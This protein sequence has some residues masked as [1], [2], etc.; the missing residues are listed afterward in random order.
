MSGIVTTPAGEELQF[1]VVLTETFTP[2]NLV[3]DVPVEDGT[4]FSDHIQRQ[5]FIFTVIA[6]ISETPFLDEQISVTRL[7]DAIAFLDRAGDDIL[8]YTSTRFGL[9]EQLALTGWSYTNDDFDRLEFTLSFKQ[10]KIAEAEI[11]SIPRPSPPAATPVRDCGEQPPKAETEVSPA[12][13]EN[14]AIVENEKNQSALDQL[15]EFFGIGG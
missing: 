2:K 14:K 3:T 4:V 12:A 5:P 11:V 1:D 7:L 10:I 6:I 8:T 13:P 9:I 15:G